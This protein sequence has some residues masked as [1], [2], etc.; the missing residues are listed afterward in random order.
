MPELPAILTAALTGF[1]S[2][3]LLSIP[4]GPVNVSIMN[5]G[6]LRGFRYAA[7][8]GLGASVMEVI[9][10]SVAFTGFSSFFQQ[11]YIKHTLEVFSFAFIVFLGIRLVMVTSIQV[12]SK[13]GEKMEDKFHPHS[14][15]M[16][17]FVQVL[18]NPNVLLFWIVL[19]ANFISRDW[20]QPS[21]AG[22]GA[23][24]LGVALGTNTWF[25]GLSYAI[26]RKRQK[27]NDKTLLWMQRIS[28]LV[29]LVFAFAH[30][31]RIAWKMH[32]R[33]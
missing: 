15:F 22:K 19:S 21:L 24:V 27:F 3:F 6:A 28:G 31:I 7:L 8:I 12:T 33:K 20:V 2:G 1:L 17:G 18:G 29:L 32:H 10:C 23:C 5:Q 26:A 30:G 11:D 13:M 25:S 16:T 4:V 14:A 9:Y